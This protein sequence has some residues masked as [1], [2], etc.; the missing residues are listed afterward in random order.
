MPMLTGTLITAAGFLPMGHG[1]VAVTGEYTFAIF[2][3]TAMALVL[4]WLAAVYFAPY[5]GYLLLKVNPHHADARP[6]RGVRHAVLQRFRHAGELVRDVA[7]DRDRRHAGQFRAGP[8]GVSS[9]SRS[10]SSRI[11]AGPSSWWSMLVARGHQLPRNDGGRGQ[12]RRAPPCGATRRVDGREH[13]RSAPARRASTCRWTRS[14]RRRNVA[15]V[16]VMPSRRRGAR[17]RCASA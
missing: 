6:S 5:L 13:L 1:Q 3:V 11:R 2:A 17:A 4:S 10:S 8:V 12:A 16:I 7:Q 14:S 15:Q 9:S